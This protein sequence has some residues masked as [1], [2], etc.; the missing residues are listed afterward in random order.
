[1]KG[2][3]KMRTQ[4]FLMRIR[5]L[6]VAGVIAGAMSAAA[7]TTLTL[8][9]AGGYYNDNVGATLPDSTAQ[10]PDV[11]STANFGVY[12]FTVNAID[13][14]TASL[15]GLSSDPNSASSHFLSTCLSPSGTLNFD[16]QYTYNYESFSAAAPGQNPRGYWSGNGIQNAAYLWNVFGGTIPTVAAGL[17]IQGADAGVGLSMAMMEV[18]YNGGPT[19]G[20]LDNTQTPFAP[21]FNG[22]TAAQA[23]YNYYLT[24]Y[25]TY[26]GTSGQTGEAANTQ[27]Y[28][29]FVPTASS[30]QEFIFIAPNQENLQPVPEP[31]TWICGALLLLPFGASALRILYKRSKTS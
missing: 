5:V 22:D 16:T 23:A 2:I 18:L 31:T 10:S 7:Q 27:T 13:Q 28:G 1:M 21:Q 4:D 11:I 19:Y 26:G 12:S 20:T 14:N 15:T 25:Q 8:N 24:F 6:T 30:G 29:L 17:N 3:L 9:S